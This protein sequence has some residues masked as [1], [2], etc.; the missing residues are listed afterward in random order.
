MKI[1][2]RSKPFIIFVPGYEVN[3]GSAFSV[4]ELFWKPYTIFNL[5][6]SEINSVRFE[7]IS[8]TSSSFAISKKDGKYF[9]SGNGK[10]LY[11][12]NSDL[13]VRYLSYFTFIPFESWALD[14]TEN[15]KEST[16]KTE[17]LF[18]ITVVSSDGPTTVL[19]LWPLVRRENDSS[20]VDTDRLLGKNNTNNAFFIVRYFDI[21][22]VIKKRSYFFT[23]SPAMLRQSSS[24][25]AG[26][27]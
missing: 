21:D 3:I 9:L 17:P 11:G 26:E 23:P 7:N 19:S 4:N 27:K 24:P 8:D 15:E 16:G 14:M 1:K 12:F 18:R 6:P 2:E 5:L 20:T 22:P 10:D 25:K 13:I